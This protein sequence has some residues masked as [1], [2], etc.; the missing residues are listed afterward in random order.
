MLF[1]RGMKC[2]FDLRLKVIVIPG[3]DI[4]QIVIVMEVCVSRVWLCRL[5]R[6]SVEDLGAVT[7]CGKIEHFDCSPASVFPLH[8]QALIRIK[9]DS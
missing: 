1:I 3:C 6:R 7:A 9:L 4:E 5:A 8:D 2:I